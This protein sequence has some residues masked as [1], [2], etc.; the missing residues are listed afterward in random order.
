MT[1]N[2]AKGV[3]AALAALEGTWHGETKETEKRIVR[4]FTIAYAQAVAEEMDRGVPVAEILTAVMLAEAH[5]AISVVLTGTG[6]PFDPVRFALL[7]NVYVKGFESMF[8]RRVG[9]IMEGKGPK[10]SQVDK[11]GRVRTT[12]FADMN[13]AK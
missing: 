6:I 1:M 10:V 11:T 2:H 13:D 12:S 5:I 9:D 7:A 3:E 8:H 4:A